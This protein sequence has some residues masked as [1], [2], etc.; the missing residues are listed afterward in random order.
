MATDPEYDEWADG[1]QTIRIPQH[2]GT[3][4][5]TS[6]HGPPHCITSIQAGSMIARNG[7]ALVGELIT[8]IDSIPTTAMNHSELHRA[9]QGPEYTSVSL[10][11][12][13][14]HGNA[15][16]ISVLRSP[17]KTFQ[18]SFARAVKL[19]RD[20]RRELEKTIRGLIKDEEIECVSLSVGEAAFVRLW[21]RLRAHGF[22]A[23]DTFCRLNPTVART[24][25]SCPILGNAD[26]ADT[27]LLTEWLD[28]LRKVE[29]H[30]ANLELAHA[31]PTLLPSMRGSRESLILRRRTLALLNDRAEAVAHRLTTLDPSFTLWGTSIREIREACS[32][33]HRVGAQVGNPLQCYRSAE[34]GTTALRA[35]LAVVEHNRPGFESHR[36]QPHW[37]RLT[38]QSHE[39][40]L[41]QLNA[42]AVSL[43]NSADKLSLGADSRVT[44]LPAQIRRLYN[45][46]CRDPLEKDAH[47]SHGHTLPGSPE[48]RQKLAQ[49]A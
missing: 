21:P 6:R 17:P 44:R 24:K 1:V 11:I 30:V 16:T 28:N 37:P 13:D 23:F 20:R 43:C 4:I 45:K 38:A 26:T 32:Q 5:G 12:A 8:H 41:L 39:A 9:L 35:A 42:L 7:N 47:R 18:I 36:Q 29:G 22:H 33:L 34:E 10:G 49:I 19:L 2:L 3:G 31:R 27:L 46:C 40:A 25:F 15:Q 48:K 14:P